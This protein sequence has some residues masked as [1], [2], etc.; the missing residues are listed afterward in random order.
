MADGPA[1]GRRRLRALPVSMFPTQAGWTLAAMTGA[2]FGASR[3]TGAGWAMVVVALAGAT[4]LHGFIAPALHIRGARAVACS[5]SPSWVA[6]HPQHVELSMPRALR[7][8]RVRL[9]VPETS[10]VRVEVAGR[11]RVVARFAGRGVFDR[12]VLEAHC[13]APLGLVR[14]RATRTIALEHA[15]D[16]GPRPA[17][18]A[19]PEA[20]LSDLHAPGG[21]SW[22]RPGGDIVS[23]LREYVPGDPARLV[24]WAASARHEG[25]M[26]KQLEQPRLPTLTIVTDLRGAADAAEAAAER[27]AGYALVALNAGVPVRLV[28]SQRSGMV[29]GA[30]SGPVD[31]AR[32]LARATAG[33]V[34]RRAGTEGFVLLVSCAGDTLERGVSA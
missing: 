25:L 4:L 15:V 32:R 26:V 13:A 11:G 34:S 9:L 8:A 2:A 27:A 5:L 6:G 20:L 10:W 31:V 23:S 1:R 12:V 3:T 7:G 18:V 14:W 17:E 21:G 29:D 30:V 19:P 22:A 33:P 16:V 24:H 28:T